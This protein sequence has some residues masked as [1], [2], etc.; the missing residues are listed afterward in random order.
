MKNYSVEEYDKHE[1]EWFIIGSY[2]M[3]QNEAQQVFAQ[4][5]AEGD[6]VRIRKWNGEKW[7]TTA[8]S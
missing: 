2:K 5:K 1:R 8:K 4:Q 3:D 6:R 7:V